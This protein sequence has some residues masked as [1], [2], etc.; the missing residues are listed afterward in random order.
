MSIGVRID[1]RRE[2]YI[3]DID[4]TLLELPYKE[5]AG[6]RLG[7]AL[8]RFMRPVQMPVP[9][10]GMTRG[11]GLERWKQSQPVSLGAWRR[12]CAWFRFRAASWPTA[13]VVRCARPL[14]GGNV[15]AVQLRIG[16]APAAQ[17]PG[18][19]PLERR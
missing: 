14:P 1:E 5:V 19:R 3:V 12:F 9:G 10:P 7:D 16:S 11:E 8:E 13:R 15:A 6:T 2:N 17:V 18:L 4:G